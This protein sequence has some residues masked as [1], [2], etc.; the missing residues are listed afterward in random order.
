[1]AERRRIA[2]VLAL[3]AVL[4]GLSAAASADTAAPAGEAGIGTD[5][6]LYRSEARNERGEVVY[7]EEH[8][9]VY[10][11][12]TIRRSLTEYF[13]P[14]GERIATLESDYSKSASMPTYLFQDLVRG[15]REGLRL[16][17]GRYVVYRQKRGEDEE[18]RP[19]EK[20][21]NVFSCQG[22]HYFL[23]NN[24]GLLD[25]GSVK[26]DLVLPSELKA[27]TFQVVRT[28]GEGDLVRAEVRIDNWFLRLFAPKLHLV[29]DRS[30]K[31]LVEYEGI[32][33]IPAADGERQ[34]VR[35]A[36]EYD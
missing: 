1:M 22:W 28:G 20:T 4:G 27:H 5:T 29:Y 21:N 8:T 33:N 16:E 30:R 13:S 11:G 15:Y 12:G 23:V 19:L 14:G 36:Y 25:E 35:I 3:A 17:E 7:R 18:T 24:L 10:A 34:D 6:L 9:A 31:K 32:S 26:L 2:V